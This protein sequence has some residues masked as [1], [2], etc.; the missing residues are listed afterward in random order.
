MNDPDRVS[1]WR[2]LLVPD[3]IERVA[4]ANDDRSIHDRVPVLHRI[5]EDLAVECSQCPQSLGLL[6]G[7]WTTRVVLTAMRF[8]PGPVI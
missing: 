8:G 4:G 6:F 5:S 7:D 1:H 3:G 2:L